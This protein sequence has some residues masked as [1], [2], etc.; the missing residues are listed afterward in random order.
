MA[1]YIPEEKLL[2]PNDAFGQHIASTERFDDEYG[3]DKVK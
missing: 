1:T 2:L 3:W